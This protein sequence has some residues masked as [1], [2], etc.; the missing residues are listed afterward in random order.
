MEIAVERRSSDSPDRD[1]RFPAGTPVPLRVNRSYCLHIP[2]TFRGKGRNGPFRMAPEE[3]E[4]RYGPKLLL[5]G[6][7]EDLLTPQPRVVDRHEP[8][9]GIVLLDTEDPARTLQLPPLPAGQQQII[10]RQIVAVYDG[11][12]RMAA[13]DISASRNIAVEGELGDHVTPHWE[14]EFASSACPGLR[15]RSPGPR[16][17]PR[18]RMSSWSWSSGG[19]RPSSSS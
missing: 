4:V 8:L 15:S 3:F 12:Q 9:Y 14:P 11:Q 19:P 5:G 6:F 16:S 7:G 2:D 17:S 13:M 18:S 10:L 1:P